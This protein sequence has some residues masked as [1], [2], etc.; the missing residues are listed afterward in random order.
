[1]KERTNLK[2][3][4]YALLILF[5][6]LLIN[7]YTLD[8][9]GTKNYPSYDQNIKDKKG[10]E[11]VIDAP[12]L[13][14]FGED[15]WWNVSFA[16]R[17]LINITNNNDVDLID[18]TV[19]I[20]FNH[21]LLIQETPGMQDDLG[22][23][24]IIEN[25][26]LRNYYAQTDYPNG[27]MATIWF[28]TNV[29]KYSD[30]YDTYLYYGNETVQFLESFYMEDRIPQNW[31]RFEDGSGTIADDSVGTN[32][33]TLNNMQQNDWVTGKL[34]DYCLDFDGTNDY[35]SMDTDTIPSDEF[36]ISLWFYAR[37]S[38][39]TIYDQSMGSPYYSGGSRKYFAIYINSGEL[40][41][42]FED[43]NDG[44][45]RIYHTLTNPTDTWHHVV[46]TAEWDNSN[47]NHSI[48]V[49]GELKTSELHYIRSKPYLNAPYIGDPILDGYQAPNV[50]F[51]GMIDDIRIYDY[52]VEAEDM[53]W[54]NT[55]YKVEATINE[56][57]PRSASMQVNAV[58]LYGNYI[59]NAH[60]SIYNGT[61]SSNPLQSK[62]ANSE[63]SV[64]FGELDIT[65]QGYNF[66][67]SIESNTIP[68][69]FEI[70]NRTTEAFPLKE[71][72]SE[73]NLTCDVSTNNFKIIDIDGAPVESGWIMVGNNTT[74]FGKIRNCT[75]DSNGNAQFWWVNS[76]PYDYNY[77]VY[78]R[79][80]DYNPTDLILASGNINT[81]NI[82]ITVNTNLTT[83]NFT[84][85][86]RDK[87]TVAL[88]EI[89]L[90]IS[91]NLTGNKY[92]VVD[93]I[94]DIDGKA[95]LRWLNSSDEL[96]SGNYSLECRFFDIARGFNM[97]ELRPGLDFISDEVNFTV[98]SK[99]SYNI[100]ININPD[101]YKTELI[102][103]NPDSNIEVTW[104]TQ[105]KIRALFNITEAAG[106]ENTG[107]T[108]ADS[109]SFKVIR[110]TTTV[111]SGSMPKEEDN[112]GR[113]QGTIDTS[114]LEGGKSYAI[115]I[116]AQKT[117]YSEPD[118]L[119]P[120]LLLL[121][122]NIIVSQ[123]ENDDSPTE[124][125]WLETAN[126]TVKPYGK[127]SELFII[128]ESIFKE[129][130]SDGY[131][132]DFA[133]PDI[134]TEWNLSKVIFDIE[135]V[136]FGVDINSANIRITETNYGVQ[137]NWDK[138]NATIGHYGASA[139][140]GTWENLILYI[141]E[142]SLVGNNLFNFEIEGTFI[143]SIDITTEA[144]FIRD[145]IHV[146]YREFNVTD[147]IIIQP[148]GNGW[149]IEN[150]TFNIYNCYETSNWQPYDLSDQNALNIT[151]NEGFLYS[152]NP[153]GGSGTGTLTIVDKIYPISYMDDKFSFTIENYTN[154]IFDVVVQVDYTQEFYK[155]QYLE[156][157][158]TIET[159][160]GYTSGE[161]SITPNDL[162][163]NDDGV[164]LFITNL[165]NSTNQVVFPS[166]VGM[167]ITF[168]LINSDIQDGLIL[169]EGL[170]S[171]GEISKDVVFPALIQANQYVTFE[172]TFRIS[173]TREVYYEISATMTYEIRGEDITG[174]AP[175][176]SEVEHY[177]A[178]IDTSLL[179]AGDFTIR[180]SATKQ[181]YEIGQEDLDLE[182][183]ERLTSINDAGGFYQQFLSIFVQDARNYTF[184]YTDTIF[185][186]KIA[187]LDE[188]TFK[189][190]FFGEGNT[191]LQSGSGELIN[192]GDD[193]VLDFNTEIRQVGRYSI[194]ITLDKQNYEVKFA[195][196][197][198]TV[199]LREIDAD[200]GDMFDDK[201][202]SV[203]KGKKVTLEI[204]LTDPTQGDIPIEGAEV[205]LE[206][207][208]D[209][210]EFDEKD[211]GVYEL[212]FDTEDYEAFFTSDTLTGTIKVSKANYTT[213][214]IDITIVI[215]MEEIVEDVPAFYFM[216]IIGAI[217][218]IVGSLATYKYIQIARI[219]KFVK[220]A[221]AM[222]S[223][224][225][226]KKIIPE[227]ALTKS[228][229]DLIFE[230]FDDVWRDIGLSLRDTLGIKKIPG[231][232]KKEGGDI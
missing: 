83:V 93:L 95:S 21:T 124:V 48:W 90:R 171:L 87:P 47:G 74:G 70:V 216:M 132:F 69:Y 46:V 154:I 189:W 36:S 224:I 152:L 80:N 180:F 17:R 198:L 24:R 50:N 54:L 5:A 212:E 3:K 39:G 126:M 61:T 125:Y 218:A 213:E 14:V 217:T 138:N 165:K 114:Q 229:E 183:L 153:G 77:T 128:E 78:Y 62:I 22:D 53:E 230:E 112:I 162:D 105:L 1:M 67:V 225:K 20:K 210:F 98:S 228:K 103:L 9:T 2:K 181:N 38:T 57:Q 72:F 86:Q 190:E 52:T 107:F 88:K 231:K 56:E 156:E 76:T 147:S 45:W 166:D 184:T 96:I 146:E 232:Y 164:T 63:G 116:S 131:N 207:G 200:L 33:G 26:V 25:G 145:K 168:G 100:W 191:I 27:D 16:H 23:I 11:K 10:Q 203:V 140:N 29:S 101:L 49:D 104:G 170:I 111:L 155:T 121:K 32:N 206:I 44:D 91:A 109:M 99:K 158:S 223:A 85:F 208:D 197:S 150:I 221:R 89:D 59:P 106:G 222:K 161:I 60:I 41:W 115:E 182:V 135:S 174:A 19:S 169:G 82:P 55:D 195:L 73:I 94:T 167:N 66:S 84:V 160:E 108:W 129:P 143:G 97:T 157:I 37:S 68:G 176:I 227:S 137:Y 196:I 92:Q 65:S 64:I 136:T 178:S 148:D 30:D 211:D 75:I 193:Y 199:N 40:S 42:T 122:N 186:T 194:I 110:G 204:E 179:D 6:I 133:I 163:W 205:V 43:A 7:I 187:D 18:Y 123:S 159:F 149:A 119:N 151:T 4:L 58:D 81:P 113:N 185:G 102:L 214:E 130:V 15:P 226:S 51:D 31:W 202:V 144:Y 35:V 209:E 201:Q 139:T 28:E 220:K 192:M 120:T 172:L 79:N 118:T 141:D 173:Y 177:E 188:Q 117:G 12:E 13:S 34:E 215:E 142:G 71:L 8:F 127:N 219:P 175:Y 134:A